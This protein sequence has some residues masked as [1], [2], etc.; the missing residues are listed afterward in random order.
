MKEIFNI[1]FMVL[2]FGTLLISGYKLTTEIVG[3]IE[4]SAETVQVENLP[5][6]SFI[7]VSPKNTKPL[8]VH[9]GDKITLEYS[10]A[11]VPG[12]FPEKAHINS[13]AK[14]ISAEN[15]WYYGEHT[16]GPI[17]VGGG[18]ICGTFNAVEKGESSIT[19]TIESKNAVNTV[20]CNVTVIERPKKQ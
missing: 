15:I 6:N 12:A 9:V 20:K 4:S 8:T 2:C 10:Y 17:K 18:T 1:S 3:K 16:G 19:L 14:A 13:T 7:R 5:K 11:V